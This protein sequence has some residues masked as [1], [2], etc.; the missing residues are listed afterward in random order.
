MV[1]RRD[2][3]EKRRGRTAGAMSLNYFHFTSY[4]AI[5]PLLH[6][7]LIQAVESF[8]RWG[9]K[10]AQLILRATFGDVCSLTFPALLQQ[11][12]D[13][14]MEPDNSA[15]HRGSDAN[16]QAVNLVRMHSKLTR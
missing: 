10:E 8:Q 3:R 16:V 6:L 2:G 5:Q 15:I 12:Y 9:L 4:S 13:A 1:D 14:S 7:S 11:I